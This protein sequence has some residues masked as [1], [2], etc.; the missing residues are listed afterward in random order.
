MTTFADG[1]VIQRDF[2][3]FDAMTA[4]AAAWDVK[5]ARVDSGPFAARLELAQTAEL[6][7]VRLAAANGLLITGT[8]P[9]G[10]AGVAFHIAAPGGIRSLG[11]SIDAHRVAPARL[12]H[13]EVHWL[14]NGPF[15]EVVI[16][17]DC[18]LFER[19][20]ST[21]LHKEAAKLGPDWLVRPAAGAATCADRGRALS[22]L[23]TVLSSNVLTSA[24]AK[25]RL[26]ECALHILLD[27]L[28]TDASAAPVTSLSARRRVAR[29]AEEVLRARLDDPPSLTELCDALN[30]PERTLHAAFQEG[31][32]M[33]PKVYLRA[34]RLSAAHMRLR[35]G[36]GSV[37]EAATDLGFFHFGRFS[38]EYRA[39]FGEAPSETLRRARGMSTG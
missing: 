12:G 5:A 34:L 35:C 13:S 23:L 2:D 29:A 19:H 15:E 11:R 9:R 22:G 18:A 28:E 32:G 4:L 3:D 26:Q 6:Q 27:G 7:I 17:A 38:G 8:T 39:M 24:A 20:L 1:V 36:R 16:L 10:A 33:A 37:T 14:S 21:Q 25:H 31:F 30:V